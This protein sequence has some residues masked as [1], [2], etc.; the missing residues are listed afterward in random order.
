MNKKHQGIVVPM[1]TPLTE[2]LKI[3]T[4]TVRRMIAAFAENNLSPLVLG[5]TGESASIGRNATV[6]AASKPP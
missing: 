5:T 1:V 2:E 6:Q 4:A 3:D